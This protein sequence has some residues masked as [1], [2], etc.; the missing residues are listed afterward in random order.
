MGA[1]ASGG[2]GIRA[3]MQGELQSFLQRRRA[4]LESMMEN[5]E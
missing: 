1:A 2:L 5:E 3:Q 4:A